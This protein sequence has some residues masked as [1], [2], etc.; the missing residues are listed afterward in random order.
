[1]SKCQGSCGCGSNAIEPDSARELEIAG[2]RR[3]SSLFSIPKMDCPS[4]ERLIRMA[5]ENQGGRLVLKFDLGKRELHVLHD[6]PVDPIAAQLSALGLGST[7]L[8]SGR[9][10]RGSPSRRLRPYR[11]PMNGGR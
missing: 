7:L 6:G 11:L 4:E 8:S 2:K 3:F 5:L 9:Q 10:R 1:M